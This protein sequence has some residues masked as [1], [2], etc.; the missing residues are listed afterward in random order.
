VG[1]MIRAAKTLWGEDYEGEL[2][3]LIVR[4]TRSKEPLRPAELVEAQAKT[5]G[6]VMANQIARQQKGQ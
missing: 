6:I 4:V 3:K 1:E 2:A 5:V